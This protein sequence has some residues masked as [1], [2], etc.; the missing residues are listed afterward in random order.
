MRLT[1]CSVGW[2]ID[3]SIDRLSEIGAPQSKGL[4]SSQRRRVTRWCWIWQ[5]C[6]L[7]G[8]CS[9][10]HIHIHKETCFCWFSEPSEFYLFYCTDLWKLV[11]Q[12]FEHFVRHRNIMTFVVFY[13]A[14]YILLPEYMQVFHITNKWG[15]WK[16]IYR[17]KSVEALPSV[18]VYLISPDSWLYIAHILFSSSVSFDLFRCFDN[19]SEWWIDCLLVMNLYQNLRLFMNYSQNLTLFKLISHLKPYP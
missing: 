9:C 19:W 17:Q 7:W 3:W 15:S 8:L 16:E 6:F 4:Q 18:G 12:L 1:G 13:N 14:R 11:S 5:V 10:H 2:L